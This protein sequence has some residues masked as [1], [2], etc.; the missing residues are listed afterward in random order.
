MADEL[1][2]HG[3][4]GQKWGIRRYQNEDGSLTPAGL[5]RLRK[6]QDKADMKFVKKQG[7]KIYKQTYQKSKGEVSDYLRNDLN[8]TMSMR[9][10]SGQLSRSYVNAYNK[11]LAEI[12]NKNVDD[13]EAPSGRVVQFVAKRGD[14]GVYVALADRG[15]DMS[16]VRNGVWNSGKIAYK[17]KKVDVG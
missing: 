4:L 7:D 8:K 11:K 2:H 12:M 6:K 17:K 1:Y 3:I 5:A 13:I 14:V 9:N 15:Y 10:A 16:E